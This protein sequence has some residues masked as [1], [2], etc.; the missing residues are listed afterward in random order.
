MPAGQ[1]ADGSAILEKIQRVLE[2]APFAPFRA[3][4]PDQMLAAIHASSMDLVLFS[5]AVERAFGIRFSLDEMASEAFASRTTLA[6]L[7]QKKLER[8]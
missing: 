2:G 8:G 3:P 1:R 5:V 7:V 4:D 6:S